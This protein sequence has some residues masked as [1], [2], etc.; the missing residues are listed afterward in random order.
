MS[1]SAESTP[2]ALPR[3]RYGAHDGWKPGDI[4]DRLGRY[5]F[6]RQ[7]A[8]YLGL[9]PRADAGSN[10]LALSSESELWPSL[11]RTN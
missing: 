1:Q 4:D 3:A 2:S 6:L 5:V 11:Q 7:S 10:P 9:I 8:L